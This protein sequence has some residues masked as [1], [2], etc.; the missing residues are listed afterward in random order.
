MHQK[1]AQTSSNWLPKCVNTQFFK[2]QPNLHLKK[3][4]EQFW[5]CW[6]SSVCWHMYNSVCWHMYNYESTRRLHKRRNSTYLAPIESIVQMNGL[7]SS[8]NPAITGWQK[9]GPNLKKK[10]YIQK[11]ISSSLKS[12]RHQRKQC[13]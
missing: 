13:L 8:P 2:E 5:S 9:Y 1:L 3:I 7:S 6:E 12:Y 4:I 10:H 11:C